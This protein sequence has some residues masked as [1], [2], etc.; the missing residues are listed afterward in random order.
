MGRRF[1]VNTPLTIPKRYEPV[2]G[3]EGEFLEARKVGGGNT[4]KKGSEVGESDLEGLYVN[5]LVQGGF[6]TELDEEPVKCSECGEHGTK[7]AA[8][9][10]YANLG[11]LKAH[12]L[13]DHPGLAAPEEVHN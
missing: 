6:L 1:L 7:A 2:A 12:Y 9:K 11:E 5:A 10:K 8:G 3:A 4:I 13:A